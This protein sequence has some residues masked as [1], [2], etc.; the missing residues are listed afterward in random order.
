VQALKRREAD[1]GQQLQRL[2]DA[3]MRAQ[4][5]RTGLPVL[6]YLAKYGFGLVRT[7]RERIAGPGW[8]HQLVRFRATPPEGRSARDADRGVLP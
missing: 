6:P 1:T 7:L 8:A 4:A 5:A 3:L 2:R